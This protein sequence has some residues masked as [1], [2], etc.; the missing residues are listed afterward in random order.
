V[1]LCAPPEGICAEERNE[2]QVVRKQRTSQNRAS[3]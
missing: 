3:G 2:Q 1:L